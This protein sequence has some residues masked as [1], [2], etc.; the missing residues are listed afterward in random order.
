[1]YV[2][3]SN[4]FLLAQ[5]NL[6]QDLYS[7]VS[8]LI[9]ARSIT[10]LANLCEVKEEFIHKVRDSVEATPFTLRDLNTLRK[11]IKSIEQIMSTGEMYGQV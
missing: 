11:V 9:R 4:F 2:F 5:F 10:M 6:S 8:T 7:E 3:N 1:M